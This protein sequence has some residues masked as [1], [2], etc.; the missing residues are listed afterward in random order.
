M[1]EGWRGNVGILRGI[2]GKNVRESE[3]VSEE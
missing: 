3:G 2:E 1:S